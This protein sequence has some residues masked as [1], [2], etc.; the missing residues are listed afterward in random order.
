MKKIANLVLIAAIVVFAASCGGN[1]KTADTK[2]L[3]DS[4]QKVNQTVENLKAALQGETTA[5]AKY[6]AFA[7]KAKEEKLPQI[8]A[9][10]RAASKSESLHAGNHKKVL[11]EMGVTVNVAPETF[12]VK[13]TK[14]NLDAAYNG[15]KHEVEAMYQGFID[16]A[17][18]DK[19]DKAV[20]SFTYAFETEKKHMVLYKEAMD[21]LTGNKVKTLATEYF[22]CPKCGFTYTNKDLKDQC[23]LCGTSKDKFFKI[24]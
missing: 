3:Q 10:F 1:K 19:A 22:I 17:N 14:E 24:V 20:K 16:Q 13:T 4:T 2:D 12:E 21:A 6:E 8:A 7:V 23:E 9:L 5:S 18:A 15:E 11:E